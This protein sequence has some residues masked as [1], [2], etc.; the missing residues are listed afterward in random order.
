MGIFRKD[1]VEKFLKSRNDRLL[2]LLD[3][4]ESFGECLLAAT[5]SVFGLTYGNYVNQSGKFYLLTGGTMH[6]RT[7]Q[8]FD[9]FADTVSEWGYGFGDFY[10]ENICIRMKTIGFTFV[11]QEV[12]DGDVLK[13]LEKY[14]PDC[15]KNTLDLL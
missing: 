14:Y 5:P 13:W 6:I 10:A 11:I 4:A 9:E 8:S 3:S 12:A 1:P 7:R 15:R 2:T